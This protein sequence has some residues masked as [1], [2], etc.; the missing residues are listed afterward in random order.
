MPLYS[1]DSDAVL[2]ATTLV[3]ATVDRVQAESSALHVQLSQLQSVWTGGAAV[4]FQAVA[5]RWRTAQRGCE[6]A[7][8]ALSA[9]LATAGRQYA[10]AE[11]VSA[12][13]FR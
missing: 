6:E 3:R 7:L 13:L 1:V 4:A 12:S 11:Q 2:D 8:D 9:A 5:D 10:E